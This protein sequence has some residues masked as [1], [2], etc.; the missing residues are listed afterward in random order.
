M[1][2]EVCLRVVDKVNPD[3][4]KDAACRKIGDVVEVLPEGSDWGSNVFGNDKYRLM[5]LDLT[6]S[7]IEAITAP[8]FGIFVDRLA[9]KNRYFINKD[10]MKVN[11]WNNIMNNPS[12]VADYTGI[13]IGQ[14]IELK[15]DL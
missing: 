6:V 13:D 2:V 12:P 14:Y 11:V 1:I 7:Q 8:E 15:G 3:A 4:Y 5:K 9:R 10:L